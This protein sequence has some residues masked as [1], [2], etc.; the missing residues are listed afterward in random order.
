MAIFIRFKFAPQKAAAAVHW[1]LHQQPGA[2]LHTVLKSCY[3]ADKDHLN[4]HGRPIFGATYRAMKFGPV[5]LEIYEMAKGDPLWL[6]EMERPRYPWR[7]DG[8]RLALSDNDPPDMS[9][10][11][12]TDEAAIRDGFNLS[13]SMTFNARTSATHGRDW[14][15]A[16]LGTMRY[17]DMIEESPQKQERVEYLRE[18]S[19][20]MRL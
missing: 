2:D 15:A 1:M 10:L 13:R 20:F 14:Q 19:R 5:P 8:Y 11:S 12:E 18:N 6:A 17:E 9:S 16:E 4:E 3:F 7:L